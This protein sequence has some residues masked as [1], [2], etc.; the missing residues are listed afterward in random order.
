MESHRFMA[1]VNES[2]DCGI[3]MTLPSRKFWAS[4]YQDSMLWVG[5]SH[6]AWRW[7]WLWVGTWKSPIVPEVCLTADW[8]PEGLCC[9]GKLNTPKNAVRGPL[10]LTGALRHSEWL[11]RTQMFE[12][13][14]FLTH[15][16]IQFL[17][18]I[19]TNLNDILAFRVIIA[20]NRLKGLL[21]ES[22]QHWPWD[23]YMHCTLVT[24]GML[25]LPAKS[26]I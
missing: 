22:H 1:H 25:W 8:Q 13:V 12:K 7:H 15:W 6:V 17:S 26:L 16:D 3:R 4:T 2:F 19:D 21:F 20:S 24:C 5:L 18:L 23:W 10:Y 11:S 9:M 14:P